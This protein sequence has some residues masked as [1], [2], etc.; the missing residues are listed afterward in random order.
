MFAG[1][2]VYGGPHCTLIV[3][4]WRKTRMLR[5]SAHMLERTGIVP[6]LVVFLCILLFHSSPV[7][8]EETLPMVSPQANAK[9]EGSAGLPRIGTS[10]TVIYIVTEMLGATPAPVDIKIVNETDVGVLQWSIYEDRFWLAASPTSAA[11]NETDVQVFLT[12]TDITLG[13]RTGHLVISSNECSKPAGN[14]NRNTRYTVPNRYYGRLQRRWQSVAGRYHLSHRQFAKRGPAS[15]ASPR[16]G[17]REL[18]R[19]ACLKWCDISCQ[20]CASGRPI[21]L[22]RMHAARGDR[23]LSHR[24]VRSVSQHGHLSTLFA[25]HPRRFHCR[26]RREPARL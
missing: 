21:S 16:S 20:S 2:R 24:S 9:I 15:Q 1:S 19:F 18:R 14:S 23:R 8:A 26:Y 7:Q 22:Q 25:G 12:T 3:E 4:P 17:R 5:L 6:G 13:Q 11:R 10:D